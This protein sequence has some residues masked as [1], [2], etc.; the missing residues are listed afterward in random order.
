MED[1][2]EIESGEDK[3]DICRSPFHRFFGHDVIKSPLSFD[4]SERMLH[5]HLSFLVKL[6]LFFHS[7]SVGFH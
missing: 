2:F 5:N 1:S 4:D 7:F 6:V 3:L